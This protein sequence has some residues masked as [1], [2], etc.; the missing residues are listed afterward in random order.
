MDFR[1]V[2]CLGT[3]EILP[4][5]SGVG[6]FPEQVQFVEYRSFEFSH[7]FQRAQAAGVAPKTS[8]QA[9]QLVQQ[10]DVGA[11]ALFDIRTQNLDDHLLARFKRGRVDLG[12]RSRRQRGGVE[13]GKSVGY[14]LPQL[15]FDD[16]PRDIA[17][18]G[19]HPVLQFDQFV[20]DILRQQILARG[21]GLAELDEDR[22]QVFQSAAD[23]HAARFLGLAQ[24]IVGREPGQKADRTEQMGLQD[25]FVEAMEH[26]DP[27][28][29]D[30]TQ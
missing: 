25:D 28:D 17:G 14:R 23:A 8:G 13:L 2:K 7:H 6:G 29:M 4:D 5:F 22:P 1:Y 27:V 16:P 18:K 3:F 26:H 9:G 11:D 15:L 30:E 20:G 12:D 21:Q 10:T 24:P 19:R